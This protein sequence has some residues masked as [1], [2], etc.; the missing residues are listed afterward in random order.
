M[1]HA[2][3]LPTVCLR[4]IP[5]DNIITTLR[6]DLTI[7]AS[8]PP[9]CGGTIYRKTISPPRNA[10]THSDDLFKFSFFVPPSP[11]VVVDVFA[12]LRS[13]SSR[14][15]TMIAHLRTHV[16]TRRRHHHTRTTHER[17]D[18]CAHAHSPTLARPRVIRC[19]SPY[20]P[21]RACVFI[22]VFFLRACCARSASEK[23]HLGGLVQ[24][25]A[26]A[27]ALRTK[28]RFWAVWRCSA[29]AS[30]ALFHQAARYL[31]RTPEK[32]FT[33]AARDTVLR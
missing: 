15:P 3:L 23:P 27:A 16:R 32:H 12:S 10:H 2:P 4:I 31:R 1:C 7:R 5:T 21:E 30:V 6:R 28:G 33:C 25:C 22:S 17:T 9:R 24:Q 8:T 29:T 13:A 18:R 20:C 11:V 14:R 26:A 19:S